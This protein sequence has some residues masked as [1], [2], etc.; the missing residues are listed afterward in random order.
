MDNNI[1]TRMLPCI[2]NTVGCSDPWPDYDEYRVRHSVL[3]ALGNAVAGNDEQTQDVINIGLCDKLLPLL[4]LKQHVV[5]VE[6]EQLQRLNYR[7][8][9]LN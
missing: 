4:E 9:L 6:G 2:I 3:Q 8:A 1:D 7:S 5:H